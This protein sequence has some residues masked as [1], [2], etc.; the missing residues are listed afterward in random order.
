MRRTVLAVCLLLAVGAACARPGPARD[1]DSAPLPAT[2]T[3]APADDGWTTFQADVTAVRAG[4]D[5][6]TALLTVSLRDGCARDPRL[7]YLTEE[8]GNVY[9]NV[10]QDLPGAGTGTGTG[11]PPAE[12]A[13]ITLTSA[14][15]LGQRPLVLNQEA[16][17]RVGD[18]YRR[19]SATLG[20][21]PPADHCDQV[22]V[23]AAVR[24]LDVSRHATGDVEACAG[25][26]LVMTVPDDPAACGAAPRAGCTAATTTRRYFLRF[27]TAGWQVMSRSTQ[28][29]CA[30]APDAF[31]SAMCYRLPAL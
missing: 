24:G 30:G 12:A 9:A 26:W 3:G 20:C 6:R 8:N 19:C 2:P 25:E 15:A 1:G 29:G 7:T 31:P 28:A 27:T 10:V 4:T 13:E 16:W 21:D 22:W 11:C 17:A 23:R 5:P 14:K 18:A